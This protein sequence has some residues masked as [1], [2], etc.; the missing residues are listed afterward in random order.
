L[1]RETKILVE[2]VTDVVTIWFTGLSGAGKSTLPMKLEEYLCSKG[3]PSY[4]QDGDNI[5]HGLNK[6]LGFSP[7]ESE[8]NIRRIGEAS[9]LFAD[10]GV[11]CLVSFISPYRKDRDFARRLHKKSELNFIEVFVNTPLQ[12][13][14]KRDVKG[15]YKKA[16][17]GIIK[18]FT[19][20]L[21]WYRL[22]LRSPSQ[23]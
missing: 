10:A 8:E 15:L 16:R 17:E 7:Q 3:I 12:E 14:E 11:V 22:P 13:C 23:P 5:R 19:G 9:K 6:D 21:H 1:W 4:S 20:M 18:G 2:S